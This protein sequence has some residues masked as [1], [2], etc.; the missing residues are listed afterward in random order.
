MNPITVLLAEDHTIVR[1]GLLSLLQ[2]ETDIDVVGEAADGHEAVRLARQLQPDVVIMDITMPLLNGL[3]ATRHIKRDRADTC[4][5][6]LTVHS[7]E[8]YI[9]Q[10]LKAGASGYIIK[11][12]APSELVMAIRSAY[13][14]HTFLSPSVSGVVI[15][16]Y[17]E[18]AQQ[19]EVTDEYELLTDRE[20]EVLQ[21]LAEGHSTRDIAE[22]LVVSVKTIET[23]RANLMNKLDIHNLPDLTRFA[24][25]KGVVPLE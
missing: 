11:Q 23:H 4:I 5:V 7:T 1:K 14:G 8:E 24:I 20:R 17:I 6:V 2:D 9:Y 13:A 25:R 15:Q 10:I 3:E 16:E 22:L 21:L 12:A 19:S 18:G